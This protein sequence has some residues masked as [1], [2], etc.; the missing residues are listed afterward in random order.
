MPP[1]TSKYSKAPEAEHSLL[2]HLSSPKPKLQATPQSKS[3][4]NTSN[5]SWRRPSRIAKWEDFDCASLMK[6]CGGLF[7]DMLQHAIEPLKFPLLEKGAVTFADEDALQKHFISQWTHPIVST[8]LSHAQ[9]QSSDRGLRPP[10]VDMVA[11]GNAQRIARNKPDWAGTRAAAAAAAAAPYDDPNV[12]INILPVNILPGDTKVSYKWRSTEIV[13][14]EVGANDLVQNWFWPLRQIFTY[15]MNFGTRYGYIVTDE[16]VVAFRVRVPQERLQVSKLG[17]RKLVRP[18]D[19]GT[20]EYAAIY[21]ST[22][23]QGGEKRLT[24]NLA[25]WWL[26][27]LAANNRSIQ[28]AYDPLQDEKLAGLGRAVAEPTPPTQAETPAASTVAATDRA[29]PCTTVMTYDSV[30]DSDAVY[31][32]QQTAGR[33]PFGSP[34]GLGDSFVSFHSLR[35]TSSKRKRDSVEPETR[36]PKAKKGKT[37]N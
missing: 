26:H 21:D 24:E 32:S 2:H 4:T 1:K 16:E 20:I 8:A 37:R 23:S 28:T 11:G 10:F 13:A 33:F 5:Q 15:C 27:L 6:C 17:G 22:Q 36:V 18:K 29:S 35:S 3:R 19:G 14:K 31:A 12:A 30:A 9:L 7:R 25:I 34:V